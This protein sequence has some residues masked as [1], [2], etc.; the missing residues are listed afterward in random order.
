MSKFGM[1]QPVPR[2]ED[3]RF[4]TGRGRYV[5]DIVLP[6][7]AHAV[8]VYSPHAHAEIAGID[9]AE[10]LKA[11]GVLAVLTGEDLNADGIGTLGPRMMPEDMGGPKG[12]RT[13]RTL[14]AT[15]RVRYVG[16][17][18][19]MVVAET[20]DQARD[21]A[22]LVQVDYKSLPAV[23]SSVEATAPGAPLLYDGAPN[24]VSFTLRMGD[25]AKA[26]AAF[27]KAHHVAKVRLNNN[28]LSANSM[29]PRSAIGAFD[30]RR[31]RL[32]AVYQHPEPARHPR[33][34]GRPDPEG[35]GDA[36]PGDRP[37]RRRRLRHERRPLSRGGA[38]ACGP[39]SASAVRSSGSP[40][41]ARAS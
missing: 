35:A 30:P 15:G 21:A 3:P 23:V 40:C 25:K 13:V 16:E 11:P 4:I 39:P 41:A 28:R 10:A 7:M 20:R 36:R 38:G 27:A 32:H 2:T 34:A 17:R 1:G 8:M 12:Y 29:E 19:A 9:A 18:V 33:G 26:D 6:H 22:E 5:D 37:R 14:L 31:R 24:N